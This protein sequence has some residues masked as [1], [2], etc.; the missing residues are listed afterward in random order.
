MKQTIIKT[1]TQLEK[2]SENQLYNE[3]MSMSKTVNS[4]LRR[5]RK[6]NVEELDNVT[7]YQINYD[8]ANKASGI[9]SGEFATSSGFLKKPS[10]RATKQHLIIQYLQYQKMY[11]FKL[12]RKETLETAKEIARKTNVS[13]KAVKTV[14]SAQRKGFIEELFRIYGS[15][16]FKIVNNRMNAGQSYD[17]VIKLL[18][19]AYK[20]SDSVEEV[21]NKFG[22]DGVWLL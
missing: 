7:Y 14:M 1:K 15:I 12:T 8:V 22:C 5:L 20:S 4:R 2:Y 19:Y 13:L 10:K 3:I 21:F 18:E 17:D 9:L 16:I 11:N 6:T